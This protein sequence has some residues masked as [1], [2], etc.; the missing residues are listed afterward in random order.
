[1]RSGPGCGFKSVNKTKYGTD[2]WLAPAE[3][4][5]VVHP[6]SGAAHI[7]IMFLDG[8]ADVYHSVI[9]TTWITSKE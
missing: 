3:V 5:S 8:A 6:D 1:M 4:L 7:R 9:P 2:R